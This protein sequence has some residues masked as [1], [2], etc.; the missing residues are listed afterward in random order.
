MPEATAEPKPAEQQPKLPT[1]LSN[2]QIEAM[3]QS[4]FVTWR[5]TGELPRPK[6]AAAPAAEAKTEDGAEPSTT[7]QKPKSEDKTP[8]RDEHGKFTKPDEQLET[9]PEGTPEEV[10]RAFDKQIGK[11]KGKAAER[12]RQ[13]LIDEGWKAP[14]QESAK[15]AEVQEAA[16]VSPPAPTE[17][18]IRP[19][20]ATFPGTVA[21][22]ERALDDYEQQMV[23]FHDAEQ[24][25]QQTQHQQAEALRASQTEFLGA[26]KKLPE[27]TEIEGTIQKLP[28]PL[29]VYLATICPQLPHAAETVR[30]LML[31][32]EIHQS[33]LAADRAGNVAAVQALISSANSLV[34]ARKTSVPDPQPAVAAPKSAAPRPPTPVTQPAQTDTGL[35]DDLPVEE[36]RRRRNAQVQ[37]RG[38]A[39]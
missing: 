31:N 9:L 21:E 33:L 25:A 14:Q 5:E 23:A 19:N 17:K 36:W 13:Q 15:P 24:Q 6:A 22:F 10:Q 37:A 2:D 16:Q 7:E 32:P 1:S 34:M 4:E 38:R 8:P 18:P 28:E 20:L 35:S 29:S 30:E 26:I 11:I 27:I 39:F 12:A 3:S